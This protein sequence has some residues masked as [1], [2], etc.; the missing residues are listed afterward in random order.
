MDRTST[1]FQKAS[2]RCHLH[3]M[4]VCE[5]CGLL[6]GVYFDL[7]FEKLC[8]MSVSLACYEITDHR[9]G[10]LLIVA[11]CIKWRYWRPPHIISNNRVVVGQF[12]TLARKADTFM[13]SWSRFLVRKSFFVLNSS[14]GL[15]TREWRKR[16]AADK[17]K[18]KLWRK[19]I[20]IHRVKKILL[21][22]NYEWQRCEH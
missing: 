21:D 5:E 10:A 4:F 18:G 15:Q 14:G 11:W 22:T 13:R 9:A 7:Y 1:C 20:P 2:T 16:A 19:K 6:E 8:G 12:N 17:Y 3:C